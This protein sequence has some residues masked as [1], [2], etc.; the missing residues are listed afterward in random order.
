MTS[1]R[2]RCFPVLICLLYL[3]SASAQPSPFGHISRRTGL[4]LRDEIVVKLIQTSSG[5]LTHKDVTRLFTAPRVDG[6]AEYKWAVDWATRRAGEAGLEQVK[7]E[8]FRADGKSEYLGTRPPLSWTVSKGELWMNSPQKVRLTSYDELPFSVCRN[9]RTA[10]LEADLVDV[11][12]GLR[13]EDYRTPVAGKIV[14][15]SSDPSALV[16]PALRERGALGI[17]SYWTIPEWDRQ[18]RMP[19]ELPYLIGWRYLPADV[20]EGAFAFM[21]S[22]NRAMELGSVLRRETV[23]VRVDVDAT[24]A[25][26]TLD[27]VTGVIPGAKY[28]NEE[29]T[30]GAHLDEIGADD[31]ASGSAALIEISRTLNAL[32]ASGDLPRPLRTIRFLWGPEFTATAAWFSRYGNAPVKRIAAFNVDQVGADLMKSGA[33]FQFIDTPGY[34]PNFLT[35]LMGAVLDFMNANNDHAYPAN[36]DF[37]IISVTGSRNRMQ[38]R[39]S[40]FMSGSDHEIFN[41]M[42]VPGWFITAWPEKHYHSSHDTPD[43]VDP[44]QLHRVVF[45]NLAGIVATA[46]ADDADA[47]RFAQLSLSH[48]FKSI[49]EAKARAARI[50]VSRQSAID[51]ESASDNELVRAIVGQTHR[52]EAAGIRSAKV[53]ARSAPIEAAIDK[54]ASRVEQRAGEAMAEV[55]VPMGAATP[56]GPGDTRVPAAKVPLPHIGGALSKCGASGDRARTAL[57][58]AEEEL[59]LQGEPTLRVNSFRDALIAYVDGKRPMEEIRAAVMAEFGVPLAVEAVRSYFECAESAGLISLR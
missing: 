56:K 33:V 45:A 7:V 40:P 48:A 51:N 55:G 49:G 18:N 39:L 44:T 16:G 21:I 31:N 6:T 57:N 19:G 12:A 8:R 38:G 41:R 32:I 14:L 59:R 58:A 1:V 37:H 42:G 30:V 13:A 52:R 28:A 54:M 9:S 46:Y 27:V 26:G 2:T 25:P 11:G 36:K 29:I 4:P 43:Q 5:D 50:A 20:P 15:T 23:R 22:P 34:N 35:G 17:V 53:F 24:I 47:E 10:H 3:T